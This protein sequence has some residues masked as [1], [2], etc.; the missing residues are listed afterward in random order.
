MNPQAWLDQNRP[1]LIARCREVF[2]KAARPERFTRHDDGC[3]DCRPWQAYF[4][5][6][7]LEQLCAEEF[8]LYGT[9]VDLLTPE[10]HRYLMPTYFRIS[11]SQGS[12][13]FLELFMCL[14]FGEPTMIEQLGF[15]SDEAAMMRDFWR[16]L[17][18][19]YEKPPNPLLQDSERPYSET[20]ESMFIAAAEVWSRIA[21]LA[22]P[23]GNPGNMPA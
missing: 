8:T 23:G 14:E 10:T 22:E 20:L 12:G 16:A 18:T 5:R 17:G 3:F 4:A 6:T 9:P 13:D 2:A 21:D 19:S 11:L 15:N 7:P 1:P